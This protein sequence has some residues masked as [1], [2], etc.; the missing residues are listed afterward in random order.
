VLPVLGYST[1]SRFDP[2]NIPV[3][4]AKWLEAY[5]QE[6]RYVIEH[7][8][9]ADASIR[10]KWAALREGTEDSPDDFNGQ[11]PLLTTK[12]NQSPYYNA[13]CPYDNN[14]NARTVT[15]CVATAMAQIMKYWNY[16][17][18]G[19][20]F[21]S[22]D[23]PKHGTLSANFGSATYNWAAMPNQ[24]NGDNPEVATLM[25]HCGVSVNMN[26]GVSA[27]G[28]S[29]AWVIS[30]QSPVQNCSEYAL[31]T[32]FCYNPNTLQSNIRFNYTTDG[33]LNLLKSELDAG[34]PILYVGFG[35]GG[36][37]AFVCDGYDNNNNFHFNWGWGG[38]SDGYFW[39]DAL[40]P[41]TLGSGGGSGGYNQN[42]YILTG[43]QPAQNIPAAEFNLYAPVTAT[44][45]PVDYGQSVSVQADI[46]NNGA[47]TFYGDITAAL[48]DEDKNFVEYIGT[49]SENNGLPS[50]FHYINGLTF[51][52]NSLSAAPGNYFI[53]IFVRPA[54]G[55]WIKVGNGNYAN[56]IPFTISNDNNIELYAPITVEPEPLQRNQAATIN[57]DVANFGTTAF[58]GTISVDLHD[59]N[60]DWLQTISEIPGLSMPVNTHFIEGLTFTTTGLDVPPGTYLLAVWEQEN[61]GDWEMV[62]STDTYLNP[63]Q[64]VI[65]EPALQPDPYEAN[66]FQLTAFKLPLNFNGN[67]APLNTEGSNL[68]EG[69]DLDYYKLVLPAGYSYRIS[70]RVQ[71]SYNS[72]NGQTYTV[73]ALWSYAIGSDWS[74]AYDDVLTDGDILVQTG[75]GAN[76]YFKVAPYFQG[77]TGAY[78]LDLQVTR[79]ALT[80]TDQLSDITPLTLYLNPAHNRLTLSAADETVELGEISIYDAAGKRLFS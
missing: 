37:H 58:N 62:G 42:Q 72:D 80:G 4:M 5:R 49:L 43:I 17:A 47:A 3:N 67:T 15:G 68:H 36:G 64:I 11:N 78:R 75:N 52:S 53:G 35:S 13:L 12:W 29:F 31:K 45:N 7:Q 56:M 71:D 14:H 65:T 8:L 18:K 54:G 25:Y 57:L 9:T 32:Y 50:N 16:P 74:G 38:S 70:G 10:N 22:Y 39:V 33:W 24:L 55:N 2:D 23:H 1:T 76:V 73:D 30:A 60:G 28:G 40:N 59:L 41:G 19:S 69:A 61:G 20:G 51:N 77:N 44:P 46:I 79:T 21:H 66:N 27:T 26:Y 48:F 63:R 34:R 6:I